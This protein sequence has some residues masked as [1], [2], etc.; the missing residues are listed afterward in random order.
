MRY[1]CSVTIARPREEVWALFNDVSR[2]KE[3]QPDLLERQQLAGEPGR[4]GARARLAYRMGSRTIEMVETVTGSAPPERLSGTYEAKGV[5]NAVANAFAEEGC[6]TRWTLDTEFKFSGFMVLIGFLMPGAFRKQT[7]LTMERF[8][9][10]CE[11]R[12]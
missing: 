10:F 6:A 11:A 7:A 3:W 4:E 1:S 8:K 5:F 9:A 12:P 2:I